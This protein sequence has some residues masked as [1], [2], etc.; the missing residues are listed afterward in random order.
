MRFCPFCRAG[1]EPGQRFCVECGSSLPTPPPGASPGQ[2]EATRPLPPAG[3][4]AAGWSAPADQP[5]STGAAPRRTPWVAVAAA[6]VLVLAAAG[7]GGWY[8]WQDGATRT[9]ATAGG[10]GQGPGP[11]SEP[12][13]G[14]GDAQQEDRAASEEAPE[15]APT[16]TLTVTPEAEPQPE[17]A[18]EPPPE[19]EQ[20]LTAGGLVDWTAVAGH[21]QGASVA[22]LFDAYFSGINVGDWSTVLSLYNPHN[23]DLPPRDPDAFIEGADTTTDRDVV[24]HSLRRS[25]GLLSA[26]VTFRSHQ[27]P[28]DSPDG[29]G[30]TCTDWSMSYTLVRVAGSWRIDDVAAADGSTPYRAC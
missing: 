26:H 8:V 14:A 28:S 3:A 11:A 1:V 23:P 22:S 24:I 7:A 9:T 5:G 4:E 25:G 19:P 16:V 12:Q 13:K 20:W 27:H 29:S 15:P 10:G 17:S 21:R 18:P 6:G 30:L 2:E